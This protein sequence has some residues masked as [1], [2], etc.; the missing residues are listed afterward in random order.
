MKQKKPLVCVLISETVHLFELGIAA[1]V[2]G[3]A[4]P[5]FDD[6]YDFKIIAASDSVQQAMGNLVLKAEHD[7]EILHQASLILIPGWSSDA[8]T[9]SDALRNQLLQMAENGCR[10]AS[11]CSGVFLLAE[12]GFLDGKA[13][14]THWRYTDKLQM[15]YPTIKVNPDVLYVDEG[16]FLSSAGSAAGIDLCLHIVRHDFGHE[17][18]NLVAR[19]LVLPAHREGGQ[20]QFIPRPMPKLRGGSIAPLLDEIRLS[21]NTDWS[22]E[23]MADKAGLSKRT[24]L[25]RFKETVG[26]NPHGWLISERVERAKELLEMTDLS[27]AE[28]AEIS[29]LVTPETLRHHFRRK[30][31]ISPTQYRQE[32]YQN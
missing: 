19:R 12:L 24:L 4:R 13:A 30:V 29:G 7:L 1:E 11:I 16:Q 28:I 18:A 31:G 20:A 5:E 10:F 32:F 21:L 8:P 26:E 27:M 25:R 15:L 14:T 23:S 6:W 3:L 22:I 9:L 17:K 2:F